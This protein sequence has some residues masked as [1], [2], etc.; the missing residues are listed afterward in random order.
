MK[1]PTMRI[2]ISALAVGALVIILAAVGCRHTVDNGDV[3][4]Q[5]E[6]ALE[7]GKWDNMLAG[8]LRSNQV[9]IVREFLNTR[10]GYEVADV[11]RWR[12]MATVPQHKLDEADE[13]LSEAQTT[14][15][16]ATSR[17]NFWKM[18]KVYRDAIA[19]YLR[20]TTNRSASS[21]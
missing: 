12:K 13:F 19:E 14:V 8:H 7:N 21:Q 5:F 4:A 1:N 2:G 16:E 20:S 17:T 15:R 11:W 3:Q 9:E 10:V 6:D 18:P